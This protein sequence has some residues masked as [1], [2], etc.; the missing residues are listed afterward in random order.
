LFLAGRVTDPDG[1]PVAGVELDFWQADE[2]GDY[3][4]SGGHLRGRVYT[5]G[6]GRF[7]VRT[8]VPSDYSQ[9]DDDEIGELLEL[10]GRENYRAAHIHLKIWTDGRLRLTTQIFI[11]DSPHLESDYVEGAVKDD[12]IVAPQR[13]DDGSLR[14]S[15]DIVLPHDG[16]ARA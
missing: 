10:I 16:A 13:D 4:R 7:A 6:E 1:V 15:F 11:A 12:L 5:D 9:H 8:L 14:A 3:D 2:R